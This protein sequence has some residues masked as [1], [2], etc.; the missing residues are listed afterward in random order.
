M[1]TQELDQG[2][3]SDGGESKKGGKQP[4]KATARLL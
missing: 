4:T 1:R 3:S 2:L